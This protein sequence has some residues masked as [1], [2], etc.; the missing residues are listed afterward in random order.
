MDSTY[1]AS[2]QPMSMGVIVERSSDAD[3]QSI[4]A[5]VGCRGML[6]CCLVD[7]WMDAS[8][9]APRAGRVY[10]GH[11]EPWRGFLRVRIILQFFLLPTSVFPATLPNC[12]LY[13]L[14]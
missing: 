13:L 8:G 1:A 7:R 12:F 9:N 11:V 14:E 6:G 5:L 3:L 2:S 4:L 10:T